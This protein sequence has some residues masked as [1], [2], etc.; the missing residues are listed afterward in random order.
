MSSNEST[1]P[2]AILNCGSVGRGS[3]AALASSLR[4][5]GVTVIIEDE[6]T[7]CATTVIGACNEFP[8]R[9]SIHVP[10]PL[11]S[12]EHLKIGR[13]GKNRRKW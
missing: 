3:S 9:A 7:E 10:T 6:V 4:G 11:T 8:I 13:K 2:V 1:K 5:A 12:R